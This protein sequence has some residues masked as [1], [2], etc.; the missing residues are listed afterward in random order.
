MFRL[1]RPV[2]SPLKEP[3]KDPVAPAVLVKSTIDVELD[4]ISDPVIAAGPTNFP[5][6]TVTDVTPV[7]CEPS[8]T[9]PV[10]DSIL[11]VTITPLLK[12]CSLAM[13]YFIYT[14]FLNAV[15]NVFRERV[16]NKLL[17]NT[18]VTRLPVLVK[19]NVAVFAVPM[20]LVCLSV[21]CVALLVSQEPRRKPV[22]LSLIV[23]FTNE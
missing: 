18:K 5:S 19:V 6:Q 1:V 21:I 23:L 12:I 9:N 14:C 3:V 17:T 20:E 8:P 11:P 2:P 7:S 10:D 15:I 13:F 4:T 16:L 22:L